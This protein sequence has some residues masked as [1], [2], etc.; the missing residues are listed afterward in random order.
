MAYNIKTPES[1]TYKNA[2]T[3]NGLEYIQAMSVGKDSHSQGNFYV[4]ANDENGMRVGMSSI[5]IYVSSTPLIY[6]ILPI[7]VVASSKYNFTGMVCPVDAKIHLSVMTKSDSLLFSGEN[8]DKW[9][10]LLLLQSCEVKKELEI[11]HDDGTGE[12]SLLE[13]QVGEEISYVYFW[14]AISPE[15]LLTS[16]YISCTGENLDSKLGFYRN[17]PITPTNSAIVSTSFSVEIQGAVE[18]VTA[19]EDNTIYLYNTIMALD[20]DGVIREKKVTDST[21]FVD[22]ISGFY[23][24]GQVYRSAPQRQFDFVQ[25]KNY[26]VTWDGVSYNITCEVAEDGFTTYLGNHSFLPNFN[27]DADESSYPFCIYNIVFTD[28][29]STIFTYESGEIATLEGEQEHQV[30][31]STLEEE[32]QATLEFLPQIVNK[33]DSYLGKTSLDD[34]LT[35]TLKVNFSSVNDYY[36]TFLYIQPT[37]NEEKNIAKIRI[38][39]ISYIAGG[40]SGGGDGEGDGEGDGSEENPCLAGET[41]I[42]MADGSFKQLQEIQIGDIVFSK[43]Q[44][45]SKV[46]AVRNEEG[47]KCHTLYTFENGTVIDETGPHAFYNVEHDFYLMLDQWKVGDHTLDIND[48]PIALA[49]IER[50]DEPKQRYGMW[51][52]NASYYANGLLSGQSILNL[53]EMEE[54]NLERVVEMA[55]S[56]NLDKLTKALYF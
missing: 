33:T 12:F 39:T 47:K 45:P 35:F 49:S 37:S 16:C 32:F 30:S 7:Q 36:N 55:N 13:Y 34:N 43:G 50:I 24:D 51:V 52:E 42:S 8:N 28:S 23:S 9:V 2:I 3:L 41:L 44:V 56:L 4:V 15:L 40:T 38:D 19:L 1:N 14:I 31:F 53:N 26:I 11:I 48:N 20:E 27:F 6:I 29:T 22:T 17:L 46:Y 5:P 21:S 25:G 18:N 54:A 10:N